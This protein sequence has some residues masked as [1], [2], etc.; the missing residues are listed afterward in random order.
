MFIIPDLLPKYR[1]NE[2]DNVNPF[3]VDDAFQASSPEINATVA[4]ERARKVRSAVLVFASPTGIIRLKEIL[5]EL[6]YWLVLLGAF[7]VL[8][9]A[10]SGIVACLNLALRLRERRFREADVE[11]RRCPACSQEPLH[12]QS[13]LHMNK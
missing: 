3:S 12:P 4:A 1:L 10:Y 9:V 6:H 11:R 8:S 2:E 13:L 7:A 5:V